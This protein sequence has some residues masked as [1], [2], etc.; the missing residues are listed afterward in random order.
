M[1]EKLEQKKK[2]KAKS[3]L[4]QRHTGTQEISKVLSFIHN[5]KL[6]STHSLSEHIFNG[7]LQVPLA[8]NSNST[9]TA[10]LTYPLN[11]FHGCFFVIMENCY[12][13]RDV[14]FVLLSHY[15]LI[16]AAKKKIAGRTLATSS[17]KNRRKL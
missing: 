17:K 9:L 13:E 10:A 4:K 14:L 12:S 11:P 15:N 2:K 7:K 8:V 16:Q 5:D 3:C 6:H 1:C